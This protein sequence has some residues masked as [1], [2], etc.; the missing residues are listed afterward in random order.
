MACLSVPKTVM[1]F[2]LWGFDSPTLLSYD[3]SIPTMQ[4][5]ER[6]V[7]SVDFP[8]ERPPNEAETRQLLK[9]SFVEAKKIIGPGTVLGIVGT[10][11]GERKFDGATCFIVR[12]AVECPIETQLAA[13]N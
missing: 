9:Q 12:L 11:V 3:G 1:T 7:V 2:G 6:T 13:M 8:I 5:S 10:A 4:L